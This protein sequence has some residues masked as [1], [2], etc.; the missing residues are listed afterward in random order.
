MPTP[1]S[2]TLRN[3]AGNDARSVSRA[4]VVDD[5]HD[6]ADSLTILLESLGASVC[7][8]YDSSAGVAAFDE[9]E[10]DL[11]FVDIGVPGID[12][13]ETA[14]RIRQQDSGRRYALVALSG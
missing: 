1:V 3:E 14:R 7:R 12:G 10:P 6:V 9:F 13:Y 4:L 8:R 11:I 5:D 2:A